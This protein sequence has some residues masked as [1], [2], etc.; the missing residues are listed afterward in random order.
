LVNNTR[1]FL[2]ALQA[3]GNHHSVTNKDME[4]KNGPKF[5][6]RTAFPRGRSTKVLRGSRKTQQPIF[7]GAPV[8]AAVGC[9]KELKGKP[10]IPA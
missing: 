8:T 5:R 2:K 3:A 9:S 7:H 10:I 4:I 6:M 1:L